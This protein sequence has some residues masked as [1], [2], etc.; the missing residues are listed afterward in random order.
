MKTRPS[1][2]SAFAASAVTA[3]MMYAA[4]GSLARG[5]D[6]PPPAVPIFSNIQTLPSSDVPGL[7]GVKFAP[8]TNAFDRPY[9]SRND[10]HWIIRAQ[11][12]LPSPENEVI[13]TA[14]TAAPITSAAVR[15][16]E[17]TPI[18]LAEDPAQLAGTTRPVLSINSGGFFVVSNFTNAPAPTNEAI[19]RFNPNTLSFETVAREGG[20]V[21][22]FPPGVNFGPLLISAGIADDLTLSLANPNVAGL[23]TNINSLLLIGNAVVAQEGASAPIGSSAPWLS[24]LPDSFHADATATHWLVRGD[25]NTNP[26]ENTVLVVDNTIA[27]REGTPLPGFT[28]PVTSISAAYMFPGAGWLA[29]GANADGSDWIVHNGAVIART[30]GPVPAGL[31]G[32]TFSDAVAPPTFTAMAANDRG[33]AVFC[34]FTSNP[35]PSA[36]SVLVLAG[37]R[38]LMREGDPFDL[39]ANGLLDDNAFISGFIADRMLLT[40]DGTLIAVCTLR[41]INNLEIGQVVFANAVVIQP[42]HIF[43][44]NGG[45]DGQ[46]RDDT[47]DSAAM[48]QIFSELGLLGPNGEPPT[49]P[50]AGSD[51]LKQGNNVVGY[52]VRDAQGKVIGYE[53]KDRKKRALNIDTS[54]KMSD[55]WRDVAPGGTIT[56]AKH[57]IDGGGGIH[58]DGGKLYPGFKTAG[59]NGGGTGMAWEALENNP[60]YPLPGR[61]GAPI[62]IYLNS[63]DSATD[64]DPDDPAVKPVTDSLDDVP[65]TNTPTGHQGETIKSPCWCVTPQA[66]LDAVNACAKKGGFK[67]KDGKVSVDVMLASMPFMQ[68][69]K[70]LKDCVGNIP[71]ASIKMKYVKNQDCPECPGGYRSELGI[72]GGGAGPD[73]GY[74]LPVSN[75]LPQLPTFL[76]YQSSPTAFSYHLHV[77]PGAVTAR[78]SLWL[79]PIDAARYTT[80]PPGFQPALPVASL[81]RHSDIPLSLLLPVDL[82]VS[83]HPGSPIT[84]IFKIESNGSLTPWPATYFDQAAG[85]CTVQTFSDINL[86]LL[87]PATSCPGDINHDGTIN[88]ADLVIL[89]GQFGAVGPGLSA[90]INND[91][92]VN[93]TDLVLLLGVFGQNCP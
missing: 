6:E 9:R 69:Y 76:T 37:S 75:A 28:S 68:Q 41:D 24:F 5:N 30:G 73:A 50:A 23:P 39:D 64:P 4:A 77:P 40:D 78:T 80:I 86:L 20:P 13:I 26:S 11:T 92:T 10:Q 7:P 60:P 35:D 47:F 25:L 27:V 15:L 38:V 88:T 90:D 66:A 63:C 61:T 29:R 22:G 16:R 52:V 18:G 91:G 87:T 45:T 14:T 8:G 32:E 17:G 59:A 43:V 36:D 31:P 1:H 74:Y 85:V 84:G 3:S 44:F 53:S 33:D 19:L 93:T 57:G 58:L 70:T 49:G 72:G 83:F 67:D 81:S 71:N 34:A 48:G 82:T 55:A 56:V 65:G 42:T 79:R 62:N 21:P 2:R 51:E 12:T 46:G 89:L 54:A